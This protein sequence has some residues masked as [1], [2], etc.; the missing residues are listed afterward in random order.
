MLPEIAVVTQTLQ[1]VA[2]LFAGVCVGMF[3]E[4][5]LITPRQ[6]RARQEKPSPWP[7]TMK[8]MGPWEPKRPPPRPKPVDAADQL[9]IVMGATFKVRPLLNRGEISR[10]QRPRPHH[11]SNVIRIG[12]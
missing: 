12:A 2:V 6:D 10:L 7:E 11:G 3:L 9:R 8:K 1:F 4:K 5:R